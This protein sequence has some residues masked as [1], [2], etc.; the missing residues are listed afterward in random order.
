LVLG[1]KAALV[2]FY[3]PW[4]G[5]CKSLAPKY[6][7]LASI[8]AG[9]SEVLI[10]KVDATEESELA[11]RYDVGGYPTIKFFPAGSSTPEDYQGGREVADFV[12]F[13]NTKAGTQRSA[14]GGLAATV[15]RIAALDAYIT[16]ANF[17]VSGPV[18]DQISSA[19]AGFSGNDAA[20]G[21]IY[22]S[23]AKNIVAKGADYVSKEQARVAKMLGGGSIKPE[24]KKNFELRANILKAFVAA[25]KDEL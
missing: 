20:Y 12:E 7:K 16:A 11:Q 9:D 6:E 15:G 10:A 2:E 3:A 23:I 21:K 17:Q 25:S 4:C 5:H 1:E 8:F 22:Q 18:V 14:E 19:V 24:S 13:L